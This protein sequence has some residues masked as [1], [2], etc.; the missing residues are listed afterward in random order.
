MVLGRSDAYQSVPPLPQAIATECMS[1]G[2]DDMRADKDIIASTKV[3]RESIRFSDGRESY[4]GHV[5]VR[6][7][8]S[9]AVW[10]APLG[11]VGAGAGG[12][13]PGPGAGG[14]G[15]GGGGGGMGTA[16]GLVGWFVMGWIEAA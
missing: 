3:V 1:T 4:M 9:N 16:D 13:W 11:P 2:V 7:I 14:G 6:S 10:M 5:M 8:G 12:V 15:G